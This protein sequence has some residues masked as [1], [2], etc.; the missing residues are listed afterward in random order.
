MSQ[1]NHSEIDQERT[2]ADAAV[3][4]ATPGAQDGPAA[5]E[6]TPAA[7][8]PAEPEAPAEAAAGETGGEAGAAPDAATPGP[9][10]LLQ[11]IESL[12]QQAAEQADRALRAQAEMDNLR[13]RTAREVENAHRYALE[14]FMKE[15]LPVVD[16]MELGIEAAAS[17]NEIEGLREGLDLTFR[18]LLDT[19]GKFGVQRID[20]AGSKFNPD[21]HEA[22]SMQKIDGT[23]AGT[24]VTVMQKGYELNGRLLRPAMVVVAA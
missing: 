7:G 10:E 15:L 19:L 20:P 9:E 14:R 17:A 16:S 8:A 18:K 5:A 24:V 1:Q 12:R 4:E 6:Q 22:V 13:K 21:L 23:E 2:G 11:E 3:D